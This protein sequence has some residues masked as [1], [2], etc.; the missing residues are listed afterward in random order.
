MQSIGGTI[1]VKFQP[2]KLLV[3]KNVQACFQAVLIEKQKIGENVQT[4]IFRVAI[5]MFANNNKYISAFKI[6]LHKDS[7]CVRMLENLRS[8]SFSQ[9]DRADFYI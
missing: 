3:K 6:L 4:Y 9:L 7:I 8:N 5:K 1:S 2:K